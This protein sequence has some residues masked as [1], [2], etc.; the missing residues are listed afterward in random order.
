MAKSVKLADIAQKLGVS[1]VTVSK[2]L[3]DQKGVSE[4]MRMRIKA[5]ANE[6]G[7]MT[8]SALREQGEKKSYNVGVVVSQKYFKQSGSFYWLLYQEVATRALSKNCFTM[9]EI[10]SEE[11]EKECNPPRLLENDQVNGMIV[12]GSPEND[13]L[14]ML[15]MISG[16]PFVYLDFYGEDNEKDS[17]ISDNYFGMYKMTKYLCELGHRKIAYLGTLFATSSITDRF[18]GYCKALAENGIEIR[19]DYIVKDRFEDSKNMDG[20]DIVLPEDMPTAFAC[21]CDVAAIVLIGKLKEMGLRVP[22]DISVVGFDDYTYK[23]E[24]NVELTTYAVDVREMAKRAIKIIIK[25]MSGDNTI[26]GASI[27]EGRMIIRKTTREI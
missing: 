1:T 7:Y 22:E 9:L 5:L 12:I 15:D 27:V 24:D 3:S 18:F 16:I 10:I 25:K 11:D 4:E 20:Y 6:L 8:P 2:A 19:K 14:D 26:K 23:N 13:Y 17:V 21:N